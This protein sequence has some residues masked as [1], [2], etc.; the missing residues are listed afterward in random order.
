MQRKR[1]GLL[2]QQDELR[3]L[4]QVRTEHRHPVHLSRRPP[5]RLEH[6][7]LQLGTRCQ[8]QCLTIRILTISCDNE[9]VS[10]RNKASEN[11]EGMS[12]RGFSGSEE[13]RACNLRHF[14][15][16][17]F[18]GCGLVFPFILLPNFR[19]SRQK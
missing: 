4:L 7:H 6:V 3:D 11:I 15:E 10:N 18:A 9:C 5:L 1:L 13:S 19:M 17:T 12:F 2:P 14:A 8:L 16:I